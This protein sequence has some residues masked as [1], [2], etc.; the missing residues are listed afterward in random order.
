MKMAEITGL[1]SPGVVAVPYSQ[2]HA[3]RRLW[4]GN[5]ATIVRTEGR[6]A[7]GLVLNF[8]RER[9]RWGSDDVAAAYRRRKRLG[10][11]ADGLMAAYLR[12]WELLLLLDPRAV[13]AEARA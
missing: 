11:A 4:Y 3:L 8:Y 6:A 1:P 2:A 5:R 7:V 9:L 10:L 12:R 13:P